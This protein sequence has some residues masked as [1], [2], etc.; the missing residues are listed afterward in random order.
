MAGIEMNFEE[1]LIKRKTEMEK[2]PKLMRILSG[3]ILPSWS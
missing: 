2:K 1:Y 3:Y